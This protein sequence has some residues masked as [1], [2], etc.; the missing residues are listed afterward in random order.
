MNCFCVASDSLLPTI[1]P[2]DCLFHFTILLCMCVQV[3]GLVVGI[4][5][6][7]YSK[8]EAGLRKVCS[9]L[10]YLHLGQ[11]LVQAQGTNPNYLDTFVLLLL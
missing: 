8:I 4:Q 11:V 1:I 7:R 10:I 6:A 2:T 9:A 3:R 5:K